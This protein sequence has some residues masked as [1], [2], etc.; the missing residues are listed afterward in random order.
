MRGFATA[1]AD[2]R[3][4][5][6]AESSDSDS[7][8]VEGAEDAAAAQSPA[9]SLAF[10]RSEERSLVK[11]EILRFGRNDRAQELASKQY[12]PREAFPRALR[13]F[14]RE[15]LTNP[16][17]FFDSDSALAAFVRTCAESSESTG[18]L[19]LF[20]HFLRLLKSRFADE[21]EGQKQMVLTTDFRLPHEFFPEARQMR[22][23]VVY[24]A[25]PTNSGKTYNALQRLRGATYGA[26]LA[27]LRLLAQEVYE[28]M[29]LD[30]VYCN[31][32]TGQ[33]QRRV[34]FAQHVAATVEMAN[35][36]AMYDVA[37]V[38]E[39]Q[40][41]GDRDRGHA[42]S[43]VLMGVQAKE[44]HLCGDPSAVGIVKCACS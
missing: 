6:G 1:A 30:G 24:H 35:L 14:R 29:N 15:M 36:N 4:D 7:E 18:A 34:P 16:G 11:R 40:M 39:I 12:L 17:F 8:S 26:Y 33:D 21:I 9:S 5:S 28:T 19:H 23:R 42:W 38:D 25:G 41:I 44:L 37:V 2:S 20:P 31:L 3:D 22:R 27:P 32:L 13:A 43:R 10:R